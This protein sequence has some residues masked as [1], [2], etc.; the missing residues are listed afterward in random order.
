MARRPPPA[1][2]AQSLEGYAL[3]TTET[4]QIYLWYA[5]GNAPPSEERVCAGKTP[6]PYKCS[7]GT[8]VEDCKRKVQAYL[9]RWY[10]E[11]N[12]TFTFKKPTSGIYYTVVV[13]SDGQWCGQGSG[14]GGVA[15]INCSDL[16]GHTCYAFLCA[17]NA[18]MC[19]TII[20]QEQ[21]HMVG[22]AHTN[23]GRITP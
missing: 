20:A 3:A 12:V 14:V 19:A 5:D 10:A 1:S 18:K 8:S 4:T 22:L 7:F 6:P 21:A 11:M 13:S 15:P 17:T 23:S 2:Q 9:D 16:E